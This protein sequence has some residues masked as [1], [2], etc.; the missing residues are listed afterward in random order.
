L[1]GAPSRCLTA[2]LCLLAFVP[3][4]WADAA[5]DDRIKL[6]IEVRLLGQVELDQRDFA[7]DVQE[8]I[9]T[10]RGSVGSLGARGRII[11]IVSGIVGVRGVISEI[12]IR[13]SSRPDGRIQVEIEDTLARRPR[14][15]DNPIRVTV[16]AGAVRLEGAVERALDRIDAADIAASVEGVNDVINEL[17]V[18]SEGT[19]PLEIVVQRV[20][21]AI[22]ANAVNFGVI[23]DLAVQIDQ[24]GVVLLDGV[25]RSLTASKSWGGDPTP[26]P[27]GDRECPVQKTG[28][29]SRSPHLSR[30]SWQNPRP[31]WPYDEGNKASTTRCYRCRA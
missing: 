6:R 18:T 12:E 9:V 22:L 31:P 24:A 20:R 30:S 29:S 10:L 2:A 27:S 5:E 3:S 26:V 13:P 7:I 14:F 15:R 16:V 1:T 23:R 28:P 8:G 21:G 11:R 19:I 25:S 17:Q 4:L